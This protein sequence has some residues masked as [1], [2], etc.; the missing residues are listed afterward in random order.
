MPIFY[1]QYT[2]ATKLWKFTTDCFGCTICPDDGGRYSYQKQPEMCKWNCMK[3]AE[4]LSPIVPMEE[5]K[6]IVEGFDD[7]FDKFYHERMRQKFG[8]LKTDKPTDV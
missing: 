8:L 2:C 6:A 5:M 1:V 3:L 7:V 4:A